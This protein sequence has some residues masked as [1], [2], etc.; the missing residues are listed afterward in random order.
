MGPNGHHKSKDGNAILHSLDTI[1]PPFIIGLWCLGLHVKIRNPSSML[2]RAVQR[3]G[4]SRSRSWRAGIRLAFDSIKDLILKLTL[5]LIKLRSRLHKSR[6]L[7][8][9]ALS[10][11][12][13]ILKLSSTQ[14]LQL[15][16]PSNLILKIM[17][18]PKSPIPL[19]PRINPSPSVI[20]NSKKVICNK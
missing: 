20:V 13:K 15:L 16:Q 1:R 14:N 2:L 12:T 18:Y 11:H 8:Y 19:N 9:N 5:T 10:N 17:S 3:L 6:I 7:P 4:R